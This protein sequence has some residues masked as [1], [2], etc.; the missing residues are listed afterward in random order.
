MGPR[1][2]WARTLPRPG[3]LVMHPPPLGQPPLPG[4]AFLEHS[5]ATSSHTT[6]TPCSPPS[7]PA[8]KACPLHCP[9][10]TGF[11]TLTTWCL[12]T[13]SCSSFSFSSSSSSVGW[14]GG[15]RKLLCS[16]YSLWVPTAGSSCS[17]VAGPG[18]RRRRWRWRR[19]GGPRERRGRGPLLG[20]GL[21]QGAAW[22][23]IAHPSGCLIMA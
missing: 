6:P 10:C 8:P 17:G 9:P 14:G 5:Q 12:H 18:F 11:Q 15:G 22:W 19:A 4:P 21:G 20:D 2:L 1:R 3:K 16:N 13:S 7:M 23:S